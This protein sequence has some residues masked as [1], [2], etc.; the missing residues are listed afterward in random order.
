MFMVN[1]SPFECAGARGVRWGAVP[2]SL[3]AQL[4]PWLDGVVPPQA[5]ALKP[6]TVWQIG[7]LCVKRFAPPSSLRDRLRDF[8]ALRAA[9]LHFTL[10]PARTPQSLAALD[11][12]RRGSLLVC[13]FV[14][15]VLL[16]QAWSTDARSR[17]ALA[18]FMATLNRHGWF[19][20]DL[21]AHNMIWNGGEWV[22]LDLDGVRPRLHALLKR[23]RIEHQWARLAV[24]LV[25][26]D[27][28]RG[29]FESYLEGM[30]LGWPRDEAWR[31]IT[32]RAAALAPQW[33][34]RR[35]ADR[36]SRGRPEA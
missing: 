26:Y 34:P 2:D 12:G 16:Q 23:R 7:A 6:D 14:S 21:H 3:A 5:R 10:L 32:A 17:A 35:F 4:G 29:S 22:L 13:E 30:K 9:R 19:H 25:E 27:G 8:P 18:P 1:E 31:R 20:G 24:A 33:D 28:V 15:G 11:G 36:A